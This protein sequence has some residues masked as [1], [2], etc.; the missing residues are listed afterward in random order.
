MLT[1]ASASDAYSVIEPVIHFD[2][3]SAEIR[4]PSYPVLQDVAEV[5]KA[6]PQTQTILQG[7]TDSAENKKD[8]EA[9]S[10]RRAQA[11]KDYLVVRGIDSKRLSIDGFGSTRPLASNETEEGRAHNRRVNFQSDRKPQHF[12]NAREVPVSELEKK[13]ERELDK[14]D[15]YKM[16]FLGRFHQV[17]YARRAR[18]LPVETWSGKD[19]YRWAEG[20]PGYEPVLANANPISQREAESH[21][22]KA[23]DYF[24]GTLKL[25]TR[26][27][28]AGLPNYPRMSQLAAHRGLIWCYW[29]KNQ[30]EKAEEFYA[31]YLQSVGELDHG[32]YKAMKTDECL[33]PPAP[34]FQS[35]QA[36]R[37]SEAIGCYEKNLSQPSSNTLGH[38]PNYIDDLKM[39]IKIKLTAIKAKQVSREEAETLLRNLFEEAFALDQRLLQFPFASADYSLQVWWRLSPYLDPVHDA[40][41]IKDTEQKL[42]HAKLQAH[43]PEHSH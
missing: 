39:P 3:G 37:L 42:I 30:P 14:N 8:S 36:Q 41:Y 6:N 25:P 20:D 26:I 2:P 9:L 23:I 12:E 29:Q 15:V 18:Q 27:G 33:S 16:E 28:I 21:L 38:Y 11:V 1:R 40:D 4:Q 24:S 43:L 17:V 19:F 31:K 13:F 35:N 10:R 34:E 32:K 5:I 22:N 7:H